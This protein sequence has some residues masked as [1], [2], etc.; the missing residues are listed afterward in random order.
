MNPEKHPCES[1]SM[2]IESGIYCS[3]CVTPSAELQPFDQRFENMVSWQMRQ[4]P[5]LSRAQAE[6]DTKSIHG[7]DATHESVEK[8]ERGTGS[9]VADCVLHEHVGTHR[10]QHRTREHRRPAGQ[11]RFL[12]KDAAITRTTDR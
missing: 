2:P 11:L 8:N 12:R 1:C 9:D 5:G 10:D 4:T 6:K 3:Y 7:F